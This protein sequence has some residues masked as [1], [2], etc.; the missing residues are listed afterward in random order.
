MKFTRFTRRGL[1]NAK[2]EFLIVCIGYN[3]K[4]YHKYRLRKEKDI[5]QKELLN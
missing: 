4:K 1:R 3:L 2:M 5:K